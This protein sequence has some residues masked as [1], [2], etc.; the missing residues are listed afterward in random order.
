MAQG[1]QA[2]RYLHEA[3]ALAAEADPAAPWPREP[4]ASRILMD[5]LHLALQAA[6]LSQGHLVSFGRGRK[7]VTASC[8]IFQLPLSLAVELVDN[9]K[10]TTAWN[11]IFVLVAAVSSS[12]DSL[13]AY[14]TR[15]LRWDK[16]GSRVN[17]RSELRYWYAQ[18]LKHVV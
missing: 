12:R 16:E 7:L 5:L 1:L 6:R 9:T 15:P 3:K 8:K 17:D 2:E 10:R 4:H 18:V 13:A 11:V 14:A